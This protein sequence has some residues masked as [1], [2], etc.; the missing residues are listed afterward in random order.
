MRDGEM[1]IQEHAEFEM[2]R[3]LLHATLAQ[4]ANLDTHYDIRRTF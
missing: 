3:A 4:S 1:S 2:Q